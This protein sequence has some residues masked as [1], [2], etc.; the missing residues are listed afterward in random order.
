M[1]RELCQTLLIY[2]NKHIPNDLKNMFGN[3]ENIHELKNK[4]EKELI[5][6]KELLFVGQDDSSNGSDSEP[7]DD[8][9]PLDESSKFIPILW[10]DEKIKL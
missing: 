7:S 1:G 9:L 4:L 3:L 10:K 2:D 5:E 6:N 8:N